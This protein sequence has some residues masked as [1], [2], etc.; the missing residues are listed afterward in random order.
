MSSI[1]GIGAAPRRK[2]AFRF[3][4]GRGNYVA[5]MKRPDATVGVFVRSQHAHAVIRG[6]DKTAALALPGVEAVLT[7]DDVAADGLGSLPCGWGIS[8]T[9]GQ[10]MK[11]PP[12]PM[13]PQAKVRFVGDMVAFVLAAPLAHARAAAEL[14]VI[15]YEVLPAVGGVLE[16]V[17]PGAPQLFEDVPNNLCCDWELGDKAAVAVALRRAAHV[18]RLR[19]VNDQ[20]IGKPI[21]PRSALARY[22]AGTRHYTLWENSQF[23]HG[24]PC[25]MAA[26][27]L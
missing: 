27:G 9:D 5:D 25:L 2:E 19:L 16:A 15:D 6:I 22:N 13:L 12:F 14:V 10:P 24:V 23:P 4:T 26:L 21:E 8:G 7:G 11:E 1:I 20:L 18:A 17:R 3:V